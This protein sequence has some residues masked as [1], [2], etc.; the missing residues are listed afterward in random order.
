MSLEKTIQELRELLNRCTSDLQKTEKGNR[1]AAQRVRTGTVKLEKVAKRF[2][3]ESV[4]EER[5]GSFKK[6]K[7]AH[8]RGKKGGKASKSAAKKKSA[9]KAAS[10]TAAKRKSAPKK[11]V[12]KAPARKIALRKAANRRPQ[13]PQAW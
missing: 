12:T 6:Y 11:K 3:K 8:R 4:A 9:K 2:R 10:R 7:E 1:A 5:T 13:R